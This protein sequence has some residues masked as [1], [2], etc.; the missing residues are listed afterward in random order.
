[1]DHFLK[2]KADLGDRPLQAKSSK[3]VVRKYNAEYIKSGFIRA[4]TETLTEG[5]KTIRAA[6]TF[7]HSCFYTFLMI[8]Y[9]DK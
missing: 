4:G 5:A 6:E 8:F 3:C 2:R 1:M 9:Y 7:E